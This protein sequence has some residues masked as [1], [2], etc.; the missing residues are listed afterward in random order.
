MVTNSKLVITDINLDIPNSHCT[1]QGIFARFLIYF[2][3][4]MLKTTRCKTDNKTPNGLCIVFLDSLYRV[5]TDR[6]WVRKMTFSGT[7]FIIT[8]NFYSCIEFN[9][10]NKSNTIPFLKLLSSFIDGKIY[11]LYFGNNSLMMTERSVNR[12]AYTGIIPDGI[13]FAKL[14]PIFIPV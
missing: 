4:Q 9:H 13:G 11:R 3:N 5:N 2:R 7:F 12:A 8:P 10:R 1:C 6:H 14:H